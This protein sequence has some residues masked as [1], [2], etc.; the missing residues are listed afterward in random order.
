MA[1]ILV[2]DDAPAVRYALAALLRD[3]GYEVIEA[4]GGAEAVQAAAA[5]LP[6]LVVADLHLPGLPVDQFIA[7]LKDA[8]SGIRIIGLSG[9]GMHQDPESALRTATAAGADRTLQKP[10]SNATLLAAVDAALHS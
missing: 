7:Q 1:T 6:D 10:V 4:G 3:A 2:A 8:Y 9:G 5:A